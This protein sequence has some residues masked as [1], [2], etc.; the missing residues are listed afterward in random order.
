MI[1]GIGLGIGIN[2]SNYAQG[3][4]NAYQSRVVA[5]G[6]I[7]EA[8]QCVDAVSGLL[9]S[10]S[11]L[12]IPSGYK[13]GKLYAEIPTNG[14]GDL[15]WTRGS[16]GFRTN[17]S[18]LIQRVP[19]NLA[20]YS[21]EFSNSAWT[22]SATTLTA[23][24]TVAPNGTTTADTLIENTANSSHQIFQSITNVNGATP[25]TAMIY[26]KEN[27]SR[28]VAIRIQDG[29][30]TY[31]QVVVTYNLNTG[32]LI[33]QVATGNAVIV[34]TSATLT[35]GYY[36][37]AVSFTINLSTSFR[38][39]VLMVNGTSN[40]YTGD[41]TSS[42]VIWGAQLVEGTTA[43]TYLPTTDRLNFPRLSYMYGTCP[44]VLLEPQRTNLAQNSGFVGTGSA[45]TNWAQPG[46][47]G[48]SSL[49][50]S[51]LGV[52][53]QACS[54]SATAQRPFLQQDFA[55]SA[56]TTYT[57]SMYVESIS[58]TIN[59]NNIMFITNPPSGATTSY[60][61]N[62]VAINE[63]TQ[64][65]TG[66][67]SIRLVVGATTGTIS[68]RCGLGVGSSATGSI[69]FSRPQFEQGAYATTFILSP[70]GATATRV[71][72][73]FSRS[74]I[75]TNGLITSSGGTWFVELRGNI[76]LI[77]D[78]AAIG[79]WLGTASGTPSSNGTFYFRQGGG[80][81][82]VNLWKY[83]SGT[84]TQLYTTTTDT[85]K[86]A[87]KWNGSTADIFANGTK[88]VSAT[89]F[90]TTIMENLNCNAGRPLFIQAMGLHST[91]LTDSQCIELTT[92]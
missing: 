68:M 11:L 67:L 28:N 81:Q 91:P 50:S 66:R 3:I 33:S 72:D 80:S 22:K 83:E 34:S 87:I 7:T 32:A 52:G 56:N 12:L 39:D 75:Y 13:G 49:T 55:V 2:R 63:V 71:A 17:A 18:G 90:T 35:N 45:P 88:V 38:Y 58:G 62:D 27:A 44:A 29:A 76:S 6:G 19:W 69:L 15:T 73:S 46:G 51:T 74:N 26:V 79:L 5:D 24:T 64:A 59:Y 60:F 77:A 43:Q 14:N 53:V 48:T 21:E 16:D 36:L 70:V 40:S 86:I 57:F 10:A 8:G 30:F 9:L 20:S 37:I 47:T 1:M 41:G 85:T 82:R 23:N 78:N 61:L 65:T 25:Y 54:Q 89:S 4:F 92:L 42:I 84:G 31:G